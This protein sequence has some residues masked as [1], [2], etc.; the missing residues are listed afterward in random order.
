MKHSYV[1]INIDHKDQLISNKLEH[2]HLCV[3]LAITK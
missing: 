2:S 3:S 1:G